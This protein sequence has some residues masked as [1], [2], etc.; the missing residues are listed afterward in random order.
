MITSV[1]AI[2]IIV[3]QFEQFHIKIFCINFQN[4]KV[5]SF[6]TIIKFIFNDKKFQIYAILFRLC[7]ISLIYM[8]SLCLIRTIL[9]EFELFG[10][11]DI[12]SRTFTVKFIEV[13]QII[14]THTA[15]AHNNT[16]QIK[17]SGWN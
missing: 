6:L 2:Y 13:H 9:F 17:N 8:P 10:E 16:K 7:S 12:V 11:I 3:K 4:E 1:Q 5:I 14:R 15:H